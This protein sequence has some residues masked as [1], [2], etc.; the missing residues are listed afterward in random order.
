MRRAN[1]LWQSVVSWGNLLDAARKARRGK[2][3]RTNVVR[4]DLSREWELLR[5]QRELDG[6]SYRPGRY[7][8]F[9]INDS[10]PRMISAAPY[11]DRVVHHALC[12]IIEPIF[13][14]RFIYDTYACRR[15]KGT[16]AAVD[17]FTHY[18][19]RHAYVLKCDVRKYFPSMDHEVLLDAIERKIKDRRV[20]A[21][22]K[23]IIDES[24]PQPPVSEYFPGDDLFTPSERRRGLPIGNLTSQLFAN[25][26][27]D[28]LDHYVKE[29][30]RCPGY[31]RYCDDS[32]CFADD[33]R[34]LWDV[35]AAMD[36]YLAI[37]R[38]RLHP[39][40]CAVQP[41]GVG[42]PFLGYVVFPGHRRLRRANGVKFTKRMRAL[43]RQFARGNIGV[44]DLRASIQSWIAHASHA[45][46]CGLRASLLNPVSFA[47]AQAR[48]CS[49]RRVEQHS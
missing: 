45:D 44:G 29:T 19:R 20:L 28:G 39:N 38:V 36:E 31:V 23:T 13:D 35:K 37:L 18:A 12:N 2:R 21:L 42:T 10:K 32:A 26:Y 1:N 15:G 33:K 4:F 41:V 7:R 43:Q 14:K 3:D 6:G 46:T 47:R 9:W 40:K 16:H 34:F 11:R 48:S 25:V 22:V 17:R 30:W 24:P 49:R 8:T 27:L 5:L